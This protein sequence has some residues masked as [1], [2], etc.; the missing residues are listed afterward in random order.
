M[1]LVVWAHCVL[2]LGVVVS[3]ST[4]GIVSFGDDKTLRVFIHFDRTRGGR[5]EI[6]LLD[7]ENRARLVVDSQDISIVGGEIKRTA[8]GYGL[9][10]LGNQLGRPDSLSDMIHIVAVLALWISERIDASHESP[11]KEH[12]NVISALEFFFSSD[13]GIAIDE[14]KIQEYFPLYTK[15]AIDCRLPIPPTVA[16]ETGAEQYSHHWSFLIGECRYLA[17]LVL[18]VSCIAELKSC[19]EWRLGPITNL[20]HSEIENLRLHDWDGVS[21][22]PLT[23]DSWYQ[24]FLRMMGYFGT[25]S[26]CTESFLYSKHGWSIIMSDDHDPFE[27]SPGVLHVRPGLPVLDGERRHELVEDPVWAFQQFKGRV[28]SSRKHG[29]RSGES[30]WPRCLTPETK[31]WS[32]TGRSRNPDAFTVAVFFGNDLF[33]SSYREMHQ[34][35]SA[36]HILRTCPHNPNRTIVL[37][38]FAATG[39]YFGPQN[40]EDL[41]PI[42]ISLVRGSAAGRWLTVLSGYK[43]RKVAMTM[44]HVCLECAIHETLKLGGKWFIV[45]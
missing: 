31:L 29:E 16:S 19:G 36:V 22:F 7:A 5:G 40:D 8:R 1:T 14:G 4:N 28:P 11:C 9:Y 25:H 44:G 23:H 42:C 30:T 34:K 18:A 45:C 20:Q 33:Y 43:G 26:Y 10:E 32:C 13:D 12:V 21:E 24:V 35:Q 15:K 38:Q 17:V 2:G 6:C 41:A 27:M 3:T 37:P 39:E